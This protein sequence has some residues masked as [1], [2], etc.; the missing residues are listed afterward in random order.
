MAAASTSG[1]MVVTGMPAEVPAGRASRAELLRLFRL[2]AG[3]TVT[4]PALIEEMGA[5]TVIPPGWDGM[6]GTWGELT[7][8]RRSL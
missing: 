8:S 2:P 7:L 5:T 4:G 6:I 3:E 1:F